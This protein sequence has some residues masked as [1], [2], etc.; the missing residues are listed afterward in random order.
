MQERGRSRPRLSADARRI[1]AVQARRA[2]VSGPGSVVVGVSLEREGALGQGAL[3]SVYDL[4]LDALFRNVQVGTRAAERAGST[5]A[6]ASP[7]TQ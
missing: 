6:P 3:K 7:H 1:L 2:F 4:G 5:S